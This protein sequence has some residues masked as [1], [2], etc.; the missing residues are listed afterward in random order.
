VRGAPFIPFNFRKNK[1]LGADSCANERKFLERHAF[2][3]GTVFKLTPSG[4]ETVLHAFCS[5][6]N[7]ADGLNGFVLNYVYALSGV[8][9]DSAGNLYGTTPQGG[10]NRDGVVFQLSG[11]GFVTAVPFSAFQAGLAIEFGNK[12]DTGA[13]QLVSTFTLGQ[14]STGVNPLTQPVSFQ[15]G[16]FS[17]TIPPGSFQTFGP[18]FYYNGTINGV[19]VD[20]GIAPLKAGEYTFG[21]TAAK[22]SLTGTAN[23]VPVQLTIGANASTVSV[24]ATILP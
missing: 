12:P 11:T 21:A 2:N 23:P 24:N 14:D 18:A 20:V 5:E 19:Q 3:Y 4:T 1:T 13:F 22:A 17:T 10:A 8:I 15:V 16:T 6:T 7:C 9:A